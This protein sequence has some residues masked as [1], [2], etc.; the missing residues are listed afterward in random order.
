M[1]L[2]FLIALFIFLLVVGIFIMLYAKRYETRNFSMTENLMLTE[3]KLVTRDRFIDTMG[4]AIQMH[5][6]S[7]TDTLVGNHAENIGN[8]I[9]SGRYGVQF[10]AQNVYQERKGNATLF[11]HERVLTGGLT[12]IHRCANPNCNWTCEA[13]VDAERRAIECLKSQQAEMQRLEALENARRLKKQQQAAAKQAKA[14]L[15]QQQ[16]IANAIAKSPVPH[17]DDF[18]DEWDKF[19]TDNKQSKVLKFQ[20]RTA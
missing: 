8:N 11:R 13:G 15:Q 7:I 16:K 9:N 1:I 12:V 14:E 17:I 6:Q 19:E 5:A 18:S 20:R 3:A 4:G 10:S 2:N